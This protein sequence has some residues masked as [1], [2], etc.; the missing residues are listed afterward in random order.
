MSAART[1]LSPSDIWIL[2]PVD[3]HYIGVILCRVLESRP[4]LVHQ[5]RFHLARLVFFVESGRA[6]Y[7]QIVLFH[8]K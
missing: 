1:H 3:R 5:Q 4:Q 6:V 7:E 2:W 8:Q